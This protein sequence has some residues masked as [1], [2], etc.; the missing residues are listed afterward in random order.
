MVANS[1]YILASCHNSINKIEAIQEGV[2]VTPVMGMSIV[3]GLPNA[4][5]LS[6]GDP[7]AALDGTLIYAMDSTGTRVGS[8]VDMAQSPV[9]EDFP[10]CGISKQGQMAGV[11]QSTVISDCVSLH[12]AQHGLFLTRSSPFMTLYISTRQLTCK[13]LSRSWGCRSPTTA[14]VFSTLLCPSLLVP[15]QEGSRSLLESLRQS[16]MQRLRPLL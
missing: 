4:L 6:S 8:F 14:L 1:A 16:H 3:A 12:G 13:A 10:G 7:N 15:L 11:I 5:N 9:F 2:Q